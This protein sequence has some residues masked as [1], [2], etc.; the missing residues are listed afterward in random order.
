MTKTI[1]SEK[2]EEVELVVLLA[3]QLQNN[4]IPA[5]RMEETFATVCKILDI[6]GDVFSSPNG[7]MINVGQKGD[8]KTFFIKAPYGDLNF[9]KLDKIDKVYE[10]II[11][12]KI[13]TSHAIKILYLIESSPKR[14]HSLIEILFFGISTGSAARLFGGAYAEIFVSFIIGCFIGFLIDLTTKLPRIGRML[15]VISALFASSF[16]KLSVMYLGN[17]SVDVATITGLIILI[18]GF[19]FTVS[20]IELVNGHA[21]AGTA[22]F[23]NTMI[24]L[25]MI[26]LGIGV[27]SQI[28][29]LVE[30]NASLVSLPILPQWTIYIALLT[31]PLGFVVLFKALPK[32]FV[33]ILLACLCSYYTLKLSSDLGSASFSIFLASFILGLVSNVFGMLTNKPV[34]IMLVPGIILLVPGSLGFQ[35]IANLLDNETLRGVETAFSMTITAVSLVAGLILSNIVLAPKKS[36]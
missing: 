11:S 8:L 14:Y 33:W 27:G 30:V 6:E 13:T 36:F 12:Q 19:S 15:I 3:K 1:Y 18:P 16:A 24:T 2:T 29:K 35:S 7:L 9:E 20:I 5:H 22:R 32:D 26:G 28:D 4:G 17:Y 25:L 31:V 34:T 23:S 21:L 10:D